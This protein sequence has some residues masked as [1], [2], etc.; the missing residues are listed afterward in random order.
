[1]PASTSYPSEVQVAVIE[2]AGGLFGILINEIEEVLRFPA[3]ARVPHASVA[4]RGVT[5]LRGQVV[6]VLDLRTVLGLNAPAETSATRIVVIE[7]SGE[8]LGLIVDCVRDVLKLTVQQIEPVPANLSSAA[9]RVVRGVY[10]LQDRLLSIL[11]LA[12]V[13]QQ[14]EQMQAA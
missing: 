3:I 6:T 11:D 8:R 13:S 12:A 7:S 14:M 2:L 5:N 9:D 1:M 10:R 4:V